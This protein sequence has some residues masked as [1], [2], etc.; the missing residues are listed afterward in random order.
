MTVTDAIHFFINNSL[1]QYLALFSSK[2]T[3][4][5]GDVDQFKQL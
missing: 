3:E 1:S 4:A 5:N 2:D